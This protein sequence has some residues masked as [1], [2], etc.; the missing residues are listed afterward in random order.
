MNPMEFCRGANLCVCLTNRE[1]LCGK[2]D[3]LRDSSKGHFKA[4][5]AIE[6]VPDPRLP[7]A[8]I[9]RLSGGSHPQVI[10]L[11]LGNL[12]RQHHWMYGHGSGDS[13]VFVF[14]CA[15]PSERTGKRKIH[16]EVF[17]P[18]SS[19]A[20]ELPWLPGQISHDGPCSDRK[21][22]QDDE[23]SGEEP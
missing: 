16:L 6:I 3:I 12:N 22:L 8:A 1:A 14:L 4:G 13:L 15:A 7:D 5:G 2:Y 20:N 11:V 10:N 21:I 17:L 23:G 19:H 18:G 9:L